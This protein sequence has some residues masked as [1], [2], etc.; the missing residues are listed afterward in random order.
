MDASIAGW[1]AL[2]ETGLARRRLSRE[3]LRTLPGFSSSTW[4]LFEHASSVEAAKAYQ[5]K[6]TH[7]KFLQACHYLTLAVDNFERR[8]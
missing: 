7:A 1:F 2:T 3:G 8:A 6:Q 4:P 5:A